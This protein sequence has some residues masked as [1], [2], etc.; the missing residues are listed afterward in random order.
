MSRKIGF[1]GLLVVAALAI[2]MTGTVLAQEEPP[3]PAPKAPD[4]HGWGNDFGHGHGFGQ[5]PSFGR[6]MGG[7]VGLEAVAEALGM[8]ADELS[9]QLWGGKTLADLAK[10]AGVEL[11][12]L[13]DAVTAAQEAATRE[14]IEQAVEDGNL[15]REHADWLLEG[16]DNGFWGGRGCY[17]FGGR[18]SV[19]VVAL[20]GSEATPASVALA[21]SPVESTAPPGQAAPNPLILLF[22]SEHSRWLCSLF[23]C[24]KDPL[25]QPLLSP[26]EA[27]LPD[28]TRVIT[29]PS[30]RVTG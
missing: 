16:L 15:S 11:Q 10:E 20:A 27:S 24:G 22:E 21:G 26:Q 18:G 19:A 3:A 4:S 8:T 9:T 1:V 6:G 23:S 12:D 25:P 28:L 2:A 14:A 13:Q 17:G 7:Q 5:G 29:D 30:T